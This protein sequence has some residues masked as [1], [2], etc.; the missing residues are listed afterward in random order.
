MYV[1][2]DWAQFV[3]DLPVRGRMHLGE[4]PPVL[5]SGRDFWISK[6]GHGAC[7]VPIGCIR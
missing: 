2:E 3:L 1:I 5:A 6:I 4:M 7:P